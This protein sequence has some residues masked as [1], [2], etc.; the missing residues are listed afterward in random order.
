MYQACRFTRRH[1]PSQQ[2]PRVLWPLTSVNRFVN[3]V[4]YLGGWG[5]GGA[6]CRAASKI[7]DN[8]FTL[9]SQSHHK[10]TNI[11]IRWIFHPALLLFS[12]THARERLQINKSKETHNHTQI[13]TNTQNWR[14]TRTCTHTH[15]H[16][17]PPF[18]QSAN[19]K[20]RWQ[21]F[22]QNDVQPISIPPCFVASFPIS[23]SFLANALCNH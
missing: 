1:H 15:G 6:H 10:K 4:R 22:E 2:R 16:A 18:T 23:T 21:S 3:K 11:A 19:R 14:H 7:T 12:Q 9:L 17:P 8:I 5:S 20:P 13:N